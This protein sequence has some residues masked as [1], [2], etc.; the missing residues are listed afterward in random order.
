MEKWERKPLKRDGFRCIFMTSN[1]KLSNA[2]INTFSFISFQPTWL[3][4]LPASFLLLDAVVVVELV[5]LLP[6]LCDGQGQ[7]GQVVHQVTQALVVLLHRQRVCTREYS[8]KS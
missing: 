5:V 7:V 3:N 1:M 8:L 2:S 4:I 6:V